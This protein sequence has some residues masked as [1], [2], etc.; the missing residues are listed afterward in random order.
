MM[1]L[2]QEKNERDVW[3]QENTAVLEV[4]PKNKWHCI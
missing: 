4:R 2:K 1:E 3:M